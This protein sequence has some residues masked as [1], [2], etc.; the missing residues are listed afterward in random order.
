[1]LA[2]Y[3]FIVRKRLKESEIK[4]KVDVREKMLTYQLT[5]VQDSLPSLNT[6]AL[7]RCL[8]NRRRANDQEE[9]ICR[10]HSTRS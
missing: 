5:G 2:L 7:R 3:D 10:R 9:G 1:M 6:Q 4:K 8:V